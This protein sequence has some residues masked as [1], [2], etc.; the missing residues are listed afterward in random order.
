MLHV[1]QLVLGFLILFGINPHAGLSVLPWS[2]VVISFVSTFVFFAAFSIA[3]F[4]I[5]AAMIHS[6]GEVFER[7]PE[8]LS[9]VLVVSLF[10]IY[11]ALWLI[12]DSRWS[13]KKKYWVVRVR[14]VWFVLATLAA[15][16]VVFQPL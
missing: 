6:V 9:V 7:L 2:Q 4:P 10:V 13:E 11:Y 5:S 16:I 12:P 15:W 1:L 3:T 8:Y 14:V